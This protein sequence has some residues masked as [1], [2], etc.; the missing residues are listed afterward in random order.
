MNVHGIA[1]WKMAAYCRRE[2]Q[3]GR[4]NVGKGRK[5]AGKSERACKAQRHEMQVHDMD[6]A[7]GMREV[8]RQY[9]A[10]GTWQLCLAMPTYA[11]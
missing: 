4:R 2:P 7:H 9:V 6:A 10:C 11:A 8:V 5:M 1:G 3:Y